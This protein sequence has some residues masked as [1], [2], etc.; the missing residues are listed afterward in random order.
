MTTLEDLVAEV[1][2]V[3]PVSVTDDLSPRTE[4]SWT[5]LRHVQLMSA[6]RRAYGVTLA[7]REMRSIRS[8]GDLRALLRA[9]GVDA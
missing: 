5:S 3:S 8:V 9:H 4:G 1:L 2:G 7:P 6:A